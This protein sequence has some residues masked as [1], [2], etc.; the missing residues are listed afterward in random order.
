MGRVIGS[1]T[2]GEVDQWIICCFKIALLNYP[3][4]NSVLR[5]RAVSSFE[6]L[7]YWKKKFSLSLSSVSVQVFVSSS[8]LGKFTFEYHNF[9][10]PLVN[11]APNPA[12]LS[13]PR[14]AQSQT[15]TAREPRVSSRNEGSDTS[16]VTCS[17]LVPRNN[18]FYFKITCWQKCS[19][20]YFCGSRMLL[21]A[22]IK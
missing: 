8:V 18:I 5:G 21:L 6:S 2:G 15:S 9:H 10:R 17:Q 1:E 14:S 13:F 16:E 20:Q 12:K 11:M 3:D 19:C 7:F 22:V 4:L